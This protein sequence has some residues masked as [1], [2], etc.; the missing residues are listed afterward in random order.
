MADWCQ[1]GECPE[2]QVK[3]SGSGRG[4]AQWEAGMPSSGGSCI[5]HRPWVFLIDQCECGHVL[6]GTLEGFCGN[7]TELAWAP[8]FYWLPNPRL[9]FTLSFSNSPILCIT[10]L[11][12]SANVYRGPTIQALFLALDKDY[13]MNIINQMPALI[14][15]HLTINL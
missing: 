13:A 3:V 14:G 8:A 12:R 6:T 1:V 10:L 4:M 7:E 11:V 5:G 9:C 15:I 2:C